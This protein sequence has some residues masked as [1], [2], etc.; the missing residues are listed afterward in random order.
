MIFKD[1]VGVISKSIFKQEQALQKTFLQHDP[2][3]LPPPWLLLYFES[4]IT[5]FF[6]GF[7]A[8][9]FVELLAFAMMTSE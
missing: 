3:L 2:L 8:L 9:F 5:D 6:K 7:V 1:P 4:T